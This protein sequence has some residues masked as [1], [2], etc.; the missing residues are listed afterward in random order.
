M[1]IPYVPCAPGFPLAGFPSKS[2]QTCFIWQVISKPGYNPL[3]RLLWVGY[4]NR[5]PDVPAAL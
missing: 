5:L 2:D 1:L 4:Y 3:R